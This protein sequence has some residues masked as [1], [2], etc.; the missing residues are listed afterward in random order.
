MAATL[1]VPEAYRK[2][3]AAPPP[4]VWECNKKSWLLFLAMQTQ[5]RVGMNGATGLDY[6]VLPIVARQIGIRL[7]PPRFADIQAMEGEVLKVFA[8]K[9]GG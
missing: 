2:S 9:N 6:T 7:K 1:G 8:E 5:W 4:E 3:F